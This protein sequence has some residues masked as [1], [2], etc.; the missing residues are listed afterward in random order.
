[1]VPKRSW[2]QGRRTRPSTKQQRG[3]SKQQLQ[4]LQEQQKQQKLQQQRPSFQ[5]IGTALNAQ[6][7]TS[8]DF[9]PLYERYLATRRDQ[10]L[11]LLEI[12]VGQGCEA[13]GLPVGV[14]VALWEQYLPKAAVSFLEVNEQCAKQ[15]RG[16]PNGGTLY[17]GDQ[18]DAGI[19]KQVLVVFV[20]Q[21]V[22]TG[23]W[24]SCTCS[25]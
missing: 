3:T 7:V 4:Q 2:T 25:Y 12:G 24:A 20:G 15:L 19:L 22:F 23:C 5:T 16:L 21:H 18:A 8:H 6:R 13:P 17:I 1:M 9:A 10:P 14:S 11:R